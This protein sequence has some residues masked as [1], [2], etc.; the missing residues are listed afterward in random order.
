VKF[1]RGRIVVDGRV[2]LRL[3]YLVRFE[4]VALTKGSLLVAAG[5]VDEGGLDLGVLKDNAWHNQIVIDEPGEFLA[6]V[7]VGADGIYVPILA[8]ATA[9]DLDRNRFVISRFGILRPGDADAAS[10]SQG[11]GL[12][13]PP[14][15]R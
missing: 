7:E 3:S 6:A 12:T 8:N 10:G 15:R 1:D 9:R 4:K 13:I 11:T 14:A 2:T 5:R